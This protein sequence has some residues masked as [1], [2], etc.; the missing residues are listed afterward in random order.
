LCHS[1]AER[2]QPAAILARSVTHDVNFDGIA[3]TFEQT[4]YGSSKGYIRLSV[5]WEDMLGGIPH[6]ADGGL[7]VLDAGGGAGHIAV[8]LAGLGNDVVLCDPS[9]EM[10]DR[11]QHTIEQAGLASH[12]R[13]VHAPIQQLTAMLDET[14]DVITCHAV[15]EWL[16]NP[17]EAL[18]DLAQL[19]KPAGLLSLMFYN[20]D[21]VLLK[22]A[23]NGEFE[24]ALSDYQSASARRGWGDGATPLQE[25]QIRAWIAELSLEVIQKAG[26]R[27][28][29]DHLPES[30]RSPQRVDALLDVEQALRGQEPFASLGQH[31]HLL[32]QGSSPRAATAR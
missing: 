7:S 19:L 26:I 25:E 28:F 11:A 5:L 22:L 1:Q 4:I 9:R 21:A 32:C 13:V 17:R 30:A 31:T 6:L 3:G 14:F 27:I 18:S 8:R 20:R 16:Q 15:L 23:L 12:V 29:H 10:L 24:Q 2:P